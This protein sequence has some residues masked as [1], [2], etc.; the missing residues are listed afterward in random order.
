MS[1]L[2]RQGC[3]KHRP[4]L[5]WVRKGAAIFSDVCPGMGRGYHGADVSLICYLTFNITAKIL[6][7]LGGGN[8]HKREASREA[9]KQNQECPMYG[10]VAQSS[11]SSDVS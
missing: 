6:I 1:T 3:L 2:T 9:G 7:F 8:H 11:H 4:A 10:S 5:F